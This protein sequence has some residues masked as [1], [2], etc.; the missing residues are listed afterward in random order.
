MAPTTGSL[1]LESKKPKRWSIRRGPDPTSPAQTRPRAPHPC[2]RRKTYSYAAHLLAAGSSILRPAALHQ[3]PAGTS[4]LP[5]PIHRVTR[6][7]TEFQ[8][9]PRTSAPLA[10]R[11][12]RPPPP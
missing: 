1:L 6:A 12:L 10:A 7:P 4:I 9:L 2:P 8:T 3:P 11:R 5:V